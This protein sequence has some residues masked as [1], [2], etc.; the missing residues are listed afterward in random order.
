MSS[1]NIEKMR[2]IINDKK[3]IYLLR[4]S[5]IRWL[6]IHR[7]QIKLLFKRKGE[8]NA[9]NKLKYNIVVTRNHVIQKLSS[10]LNPMN[11]DSDLKEILSKLSLEAKLKY[12][13][14]L[15]SDIKTPFLAQLMTKIPPNVLSNTECNIPS[16]N[17]K[18][19]PSNMNEP[20][21]QKSENIIVEN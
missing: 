20:K 17:N 16:I 18:K 4:Q 13:H 7:A 6:L 14:Y 9:K 19:Q 8:E 21:Q 1:D 5:F 2:T 15:K 12:F 3:L 11:D 10:T